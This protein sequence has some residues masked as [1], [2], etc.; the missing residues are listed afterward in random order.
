MR[1]ILS[2]KD[3]L[4]EGKKVLVRLD[5]NVPLSEEG[6]ITDNSRIVAALPTIK[7]LLSKNCAVIIMSHLGRPKK[8]DQ[9]R[10]SLKPIGE[11]LSRLLGTPVK[12]APDCIGEA[13]EKMAAE[14]KP[15]EILLLENLR[16]HAAEEDP[17]KEP[18]FGKKLSSLAEAYIDDAFGCA[19]RAHASI[20][21]VPKWMHGNAA[22]GFLME[23][24]ISFLGQ[25]LQ[26]PVRPFLAI[27]G[28]AKISSKFTVLKALSIKADQL[29]IGGA[30][31][32]T[33]FKAQGIPVGNSLVEDHFL[34]QAKEILTSKTLLLPKDMIIEREGEVQL[35]SMNHGIPPGWKGMDIGPETI[36]NYT[37]AMGHAKTIF[38]NGPMGLFEK[39]EFAKGTEAIGKALTHSKGTTIVGGGETAAAM[40]HIEGKEKISHISTGGGA[41]LEYIESG[42]LPGIEA[43]RT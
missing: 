41:S 42:T 15:K 22:A 30:M 4:L 34:E 19:H 26:N 38:W 1:N 3:L 20:V 7:D 21:D 32:F 10:L 37:H 40:N 2:I 24:E 18:S 29:A 16:L 43:L 39:P 12:M 8:G 13:T 6:K 28:G 17:T 9:A 35:V 33:F 25:T 5:L 23:K 14:L 36:A 27:I 31:A 11:E